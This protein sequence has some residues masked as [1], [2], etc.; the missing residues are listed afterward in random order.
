MT[1]LRENRTFLLT[2]AAVLAAFTILYVLPPPVLLR[3]DLDTGWC[4]ALVEEFLRHAQVGI[5]LV[6]TYGPWGFL[7]EPRGN[8]AIYGWLVF[9][10]LVLA[11]GTSL[12]AALI[13][14]TRIRAWG[15][16]ALW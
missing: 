13:A 5:D 9:G 15:W 7:G 3:D 6:F 2:A 8:Q 16:R 1:A 14:V 10:R 12:G 4:A 11:L